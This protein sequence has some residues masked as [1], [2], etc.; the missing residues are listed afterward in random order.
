MAAAGHRGGVVER[1][2]LHPGSSAGPDAVPDSTS[3]ARRCRP[4]A[5]LTTQPGYMMPVSWEGT[6]YGG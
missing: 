3:E 2:K 5:W 1:L 4:R 6:S